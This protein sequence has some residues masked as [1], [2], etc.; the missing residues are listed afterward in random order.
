[1]R[2]AYGL[3]YPATEDAGK[4]RE[5]CGLSAESIPGRSFRFDP[6]CIGLDTDF[7]RTTESMQLEG[8]GA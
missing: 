6:N 8:R 7:V 3:P 5:E 2:A 4:K 1:M